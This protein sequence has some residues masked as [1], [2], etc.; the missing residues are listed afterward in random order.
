MKVN[1]V[2]IGLMGCGE[3]AAKAAVPAIQA[4]EW[5]QVVAT[6][7]TKI[8]LARDLAEKTG[9]AFH[10]DDA[11]ALVAHPEVEAVIISAPHFLH[12]PLGIKA[13]KQKKHVMVEKPIA[14]TMKDARKLVETCRKQRVKLSVAY[15][16]RTALDS[17][18]AAELIRKGVLGKLTGFSLISMSEKKESYWSGGFTGRVKTDWRTKRATAGGGY[19]IMNFT[20]NID[21]IQAMLNLKPRSVFAQYDTFRTKVE[22]EDYVSVV[23]RYTNGAIGTFLGSTIC[24]GRFGA[25]DHIYGT[26]GTVVLGNPLKVFTRRKIDGL[27][28][29]EWNEIE[30]PKNNSR[31]DLIENFARAIRGK[32]KLAVTGASGCTSLEVIEAAYRSQELGRPVVFK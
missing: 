20:H 31:A 22:V 7:D 21:M 32:G 8:D 24:P 19:L 9:A 4:T 1:P 2:R 5:A 28:P 23:V 3:I 12:V 10:T 13:A 26:H 27:K 18:K 30:V 15:V 11:D 14:T 29:D 17:I 16:K 6:M 25:P